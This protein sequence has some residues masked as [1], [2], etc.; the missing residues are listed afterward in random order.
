MHRKTVGE[1]LTEYPEAISV[2]DV[3]IVG[4]FFFCTFQNFLNKYLLLL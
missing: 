1:E 3:E 2:T 4:E